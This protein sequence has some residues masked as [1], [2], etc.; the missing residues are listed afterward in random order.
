MRDNVARAVQEL[1][2]LD[3]AEDDITASFRHAGFSLALDGSEN[4]LARV[5]LPKSGRW[6]YPRYSG[7]VVDGPHAAQHGQG[8]VVTGVGSVVVRRDEAVDSTEKS[9]P[10]GSKQPE[11]LWNERVS[12]SETQPPYD[13]VFETEKEKKDKSNKIAPP[14]K[15]TKKRKGNCKQEPELSEGTEGSEDEL[16]ADHHPEWDIFAFISELG[17]AV[18]FR[19]G[20]VLHSDRGRVKLQYLGFD[21]KKSSDAFSASYAPAWKLTGKANVSRGL[22]EEQ[23]WRKPKDSCAPLVVTIDEDEVLFE[24]VYLTPEGKLTASDV[25]QIKAALA[26][27]APVGLEPAPAP[28][29]PPKKKSKR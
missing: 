21:Q 16:A 24:P 18:S 8:L 29:A 20:H 26:E 5:Q 4:H 22:T 2:Y 25:Q 13:T 11:A 1:W 3:M 23:A 12:V 9:S 6:I 7:V 15:W 27:L 10:A 28:K 17:S 19:L 14:T